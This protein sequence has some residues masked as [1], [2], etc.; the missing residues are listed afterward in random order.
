MKRLNLILICMCFI[1]ILCSCGSVEKKTKKKQS[2]NIKV[3]QGS[4][5]EDIVSMLDILSVNEVFE[6]ISDIDFNLSPDFDEQK[7]RIET[8][9]DSENSTKDINY[10]SGDTLIYTRYEGYGEEAFANYTK[11]N[12]GLPA[13]V[14]YFTDSGDNRTVC[15]ETS[16]Y[17]LYANTVDE[18]LQYGMGD[19]EIIISAENSIKPFDAA[20]TYYFDNGVATFKNASYYENGNYIHYSFYIDADSVEDEYSRVLVS[21]E[22]PKVSEDVSKLLVEDRRYDYAAILVSNANKWY[23]AEDN[24]YVE[25]ELCFAFDSE[26]RAT[27]YMKDNSIDGIVDDYGDYVVKVND[28]ILKISKDFITNEEN[29]EHYVTQEIEDSYY[30]TILVDENGVVTDLESASISLY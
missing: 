23:N 17:S 4:K 13:T 10:Y 20:V 29:F 2:Y 27:E 1:F 21:G 3:V 6:D 16:K 9:E 12:S 7:Y 14:K 15:I 26:E 8:V 19:V 22:A 11:S 18:S 24:W 30:Q 25:T 5:C 28:V